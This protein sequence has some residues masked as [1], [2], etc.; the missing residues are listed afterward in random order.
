MKTYTICPACHAVNGVDPAREG[1]HCGVC[2][3][4]LGAF[5]RGITE[6][7]TQSLDLLVKAAPLPMLTDFWAPWCGPC[8]MFAPT[9]QQAASQ[10]ADRFLFTKLDTQAHPQAGERHGIQAIPTLVLFKGGREKDRISGA[11][12]LPQLM[13]WAQRAAR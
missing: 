5:R 10:A 2:K 4:E 8:K 12:P 3:A 6:L 11:L 13:E 1:A 7:D 9:Y